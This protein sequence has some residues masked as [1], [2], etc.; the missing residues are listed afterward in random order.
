MNLLEFYRREYNRGWN[1]VAEIA[2]D[3]IAHTQ[4]VAATKEVAQFYEV[5]RLFFAAEADSPDQYE[6]M[7]KLQEVFECAGDEDTA[8]RGAMITASDCL[9]E[10]HAVMRS[11]HGK[12]RVKWA[13]ICLDGYLLPEAELL[14]NFHL[15]GKEVGKNNA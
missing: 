3:A 1:A 6:A 5:F 9:H 15:F 10:H 13:T 14:A 4:A 7:L 11:I 12:R 2:A 8:K